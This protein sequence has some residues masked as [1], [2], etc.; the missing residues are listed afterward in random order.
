MGPLSFLPIWVRLLIGITVGIVILYAIY[1]SG[2][3]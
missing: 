2:E 1:K 3:V